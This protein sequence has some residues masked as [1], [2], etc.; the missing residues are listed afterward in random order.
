MADEARAAGD[1]RTRGARRHR[2]RAV[3]RAHTVA[4]AVGRRSDSRALRLL[5]REGEAAAHRA[6]R[7]GVQRAAQHGRG[8]D[9]RRRCSA[10]GLGRSADRDRAW[11]AAARG[12]VAVDVALGPAAELPRRPGDRAGAQ[13]GA[14]AHAA[15][16][17]DVGA[18]GP[19][20]RPSAAADRLRR[21]P[22]ARSLGARLGRGRAPRP[23]RVQVHPP[24]PGLLDDRPVGDGR[25]VLLRDAQEGGPDARRR[26]ELAGAG[27][28]AR[29]R[30]LDGALRRHDRL[31]LRAPARG[32]RRLR[33][34]RDDGGVDAAE[35]QPHAPCR[36]RPARRALP[37]RGD[38]PQRPP[39]H[40]GR[41]AVGVGPGA[42]G[43]RALRPLL[44][45][46][47][48]AAPGGAPQLPAGG[49]GR[50]ARVAGRPCPRRRPVAAR[51]S[52]AP[53]RAEGARGRAERLAARSQ[54]RERA[55]RTRHVG[56]DE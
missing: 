20:P 3:R 35:L 5:P 1:R 11:A 46:A 29:H 7:R 22:A 6:A 43:G 24:A 49:A 41:R 45:R 36:A 14:D 9:D 21:H 10:D 30:A 4:G 31:R 15:R 37:A 17:R 27:D 47:D 26:Q 42:A 32:G 56:L 48:H 33:E 53:A 50:A 16:D 51:P 55:G 52:P 12:L 34:C 40:R 28:R 44:G 19:R 39:V 38:L 18:D 54:A 2:D 8:P 13:P 23:R 25:R